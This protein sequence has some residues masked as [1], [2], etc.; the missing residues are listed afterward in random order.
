MRSDDATVL[1][2]DDDAEMLESLRK[3]IAK[4]GFGVLTAPNGSE[5]LARLRQ[6]AVD[7]VLTDLRMPALDGMALLKIARTIS[8][9]VQVII[10]TA[11]GTVDRA[12]EALKAG[13][14]SF[15]LKPFKAATLFNAIEAA[16]ERRTLEVAPGARPAAAPL[17]GIVGD[18]KPLRAI[19]DLVARVAPTTA[20]VLIEGDSGTGKELVADAIH[21]LS[22]RRDQRMIKVNCA[23]LPETLLEAEL[24]GHEKGAFTSAVSARRGRFELA[25]EGSIFL[26]EIGVLRP[27]AQIKLLRILQNGE[28]AR[29]GSSETR[30]VDVRVISATNVPLEQALASGAFRDDLYYRLNVVKIHLPALREHVEDIPAL[31]D[32]FIRKFSDKDH[33]PIRGIT[34]QAMNMF[35]R[36]HWPGNVRELENAV[37]RAV[38][39]ARTDVIGADDLP[40][41]VRTLPEKPNDLVIPIGTPMRDVQRRIIEETLKFTDGDKSAAAGLLG[42][43]PRTI[44]R[45]LSDKDED[46]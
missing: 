31:V 3:V 27:S 44:T 39:L 26:D 20:A 36:Y 33:K 30:H 42:I 40:D 17:P 19:A 14:S 10:L 21:A 13:A 46:A 16:L 18:S 22:P 45:R 25:H 1:I 9:H 15:I 32:H 12:V 41:P 7:V 5:G 4:R 8:P 11:Y 38:V 6:H 34:R 2:V 43:A 37:E 29:L 23:A 35:E 28:M 24:F